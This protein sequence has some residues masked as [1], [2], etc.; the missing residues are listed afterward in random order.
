MD[1]INIA[2]TGHRNWSNAAL[3][4]QRL[5]LALDEFIRS[6]SLVDIE[7]KHIKMLHGCAR[8]VDLWFGNYAV[9]NRIAVDLYLP[10]K[11]TMQISRGQFSPGNI[12]DL[13]IQYAAAEKV[14][15]VNKKF[16]FYGYQIR[17]KVLVD[18]CDILLYDFTRSRSGSGN[19]LRYAEKM[20]KRTLDLRRFEEKAYFEPS[21]HDIKLLFE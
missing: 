5:W 18:N 13:N 19:A 10:F 7:P 11:R 3:E 4:E 17:N 2:I 12:V 9:D 21:I 15:V 16:S 14:V 8:G 6:L 1:S 20:G